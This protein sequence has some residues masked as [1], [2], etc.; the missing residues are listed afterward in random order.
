[1]Q[2]HGMGDAS[3]AQLHQLLAFNA[4]GAHYVSCQIHPCFGIQMLSAH[5]M[6][7]SCLTD[8]EGGQGA[9]S[10]GICPPL[11]GWVLVCLPAGGVQYS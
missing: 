2:S 5:G 6:L 10:N 8:G 9:P 1:M 7:F 3:A 11:A 4:W